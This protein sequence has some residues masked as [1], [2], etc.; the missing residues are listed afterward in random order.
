[1]TALD[2]CRHRQPTPAAVAPGD[3]AQIV[4]AEQVAL[5]FRSFLLSLAATVA[6]AALFAA[7]LWDVVDPY[8]IALWGALLA[9]VTLLRLLLA[10]NYRRRRPAAERV[11]AWERLFMIGATA[12]GATWG[13]GGVLLFPA[14]NFEHQIIVVLVIVGMC[15]GATTTLSV[16]RAAAYSFLVTAMLPVM[17][18]LFLQ[19]HHL[20]TIVG[21][22]ILLS[23]AFFFSSAQAS[24][25]NTEENIRMRLAAQDKEQSL[26]LA[27]QAAEAASQ[28]KSDF[29]SNVS[30]EVRTPLNVIQGMTHMVLQTSLDGRQR[31]YL[32][33]IQHAA[34]TLL[35][36][37]DQILEFSRAERG[38]LESRSA[39]FSLRGE[40]A[41]LRR[42]LR[43]RATVS[44]S[45]LAVAIDPALPDALVGDARHLRQILGNLLDNAFKFSDGGEVELRVSAAPQSIPG[46]G[47]PGAGHVDLVF[48]VSD[49]GP[50]IEAAKLAQ[51]FEPFRQG[52]GSR[53]RRHGGVG[54][55]LAVV[56]KLAELLGGRVY[57]D[58]ELGHGSR[59]VVELPFGL[60]AAVAVPD[61]T[62][63]E[64]AGE[65]R[66]VPPGTA[67]PRAFDRERV[68]ALLRRLRQQTEDYDVDASVT[69]EALAGEIAG[70]GDPP[71]M[72]T[73]RKLVAGYEFDRAMVVLP[74][75][76]QALE[77]APGADA[78]PSR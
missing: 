45:P 61:G 46:G 62:A 9:V 28:A 49:T 42:S 15:A 32:D 55:G 68:A 67:A 33:K 70:P 20:S 29:L 72:R 36:I 73:L 7:A 52:D 64:D 43:D 48:E 41:G 24:Y 60:Q 26:L 4:R 14:D 50:G 16:V 3:E 31:G 66:D 77:L 30:H 12:A 53:T 78:G 17:V 57:A 35:G 11:G 5:L 40:I 58:S 37:I 69:L 51:L 59:F 23:F 38:I 44:G 19:D 6:A 18:L 8:R 22:M 65:A 56:H 47:A 34:E 25:R 27:K 2:R 21:L 75:L 10:V 74:V 13:L 63:G 71:G 1:M 39:D 54:M 76:E